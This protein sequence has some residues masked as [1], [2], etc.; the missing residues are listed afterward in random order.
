[1]RGKN[2]YGTLEGG[3][4][5]FRFYDTGTTTYWCLCS[6]ASYGP[7]GG[8]VHITTCGNTERTCFRKVKEEKNKPSLK[9]PEV[10]E[11]EKNKRM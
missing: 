5:P 10:N 8:V 6:M 9:S 3:E 11:K 2:A 1:M 4:D 7:N